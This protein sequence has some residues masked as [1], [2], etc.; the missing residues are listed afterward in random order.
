LLKRG[1][2]NIVIE[3]PVVASELLDFHDPAD[4]DARIT[5][6]ADRVILLNLI[7]TIKQDS[8]ALGMRADIVAIERKPTDIIVI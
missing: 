7:R 3:Y 6:P 8:L 4:L 5:N 2:H 1:I